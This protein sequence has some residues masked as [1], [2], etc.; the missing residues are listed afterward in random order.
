M[1]T[2]EL[3][4]NGSPRALRRE[5]CALASPLALYHGG[6][7]TQGHLAFNLYG[8]LSKPCVLVLGGI[9]S[10]RDI[11]HVTEQYASGWWQY[12]LDTHAID[13]REFCVLGIDYLGG[14]GQSS[15][16]DEANAPH[17]LAISTYDQ[18]HAIN[19]LREHLNL[20][21]FY[22]VIGSSYG[23]MVALALAEQYPTTIQRA[24]IISAADRACPLST[25][26][27]Y[28]Q[29]QIVQLGNST[30]QT[31]SALAIARELAMVSYRSGEE[32]RS[33]FQNH[34]GIDQNGF[35]SDVV[36][37]LIN[38]GRDFSRKFCAQA[39]LNLSQSI[40]LHRVDIRKITCQTTCV[41]VQSDRLIPAAM[42]ETM[43][44]TMNAQLHRLQSIYGHDAFLKEKTSIAWIVNNFLK[45]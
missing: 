43:A 31:Q 25:A 32:F 30:G 15:R 40:D 2:L 11:A 39:F 35:Q 20:D 42:I 7:I 12:Q 38:R 37:Y 33:R 1:N 6:S 5:L 29:R 3:I 36:D 18:A 23:G 9:S 34:S 28:I 16:A 4:A 24:L 41:A 21:N 22:A 14:N 27:R 44:Q 8:D 10:G 19:E 26:Q 13:C 17:L 45:N